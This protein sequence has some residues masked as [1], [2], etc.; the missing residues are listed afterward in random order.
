M[1]I[2][3]MVKDFI[4]QISDARKAAFDKG[5]ITTKYEIKGITT[6]KLDDFAKSLVKIGADFYELPRENYEE[7]VLSGFYIAHSNFPM[8]DKM[9]MLRRFL[10]FIDNWGA[11]DAVVSR[12]KGFESEKEF[13]YSLL[14]SDE[15]FKIRFGIVWLLKFQ[16]KSNLKRVIIEIDKVQNSDYYVEMAKAW[17]YAEAF[18][19]NY[20]YMY[21]FLQKLDNAYVRNKT[22]QKVCDSFRISEEEKNKLKKLRIKEKKIK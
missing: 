9:T 17:C 1:Q 3:E 21:N 18:I 20:D 10:P 19:Y 15:P 13:F 2:R 8:E 22:V 11:C 16:L 14:K 5:I 7:I 4:Q 6:K 12:L